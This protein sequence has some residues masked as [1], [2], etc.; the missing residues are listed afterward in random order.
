MKRLF[1]LSLGVIA[2]A[3]APAF[4][5]QPT[6]AAGPMTKVHGHVTNPSSAPQTGGVITFLEVIRPSQGPGLPA[7]T[8]ERASFDV[9]K[10]GNYSGEVPAG[11]YAVVY[12]AQGME[13]DKQADRIDGIKVVA[14]MDNQI[15]DD[16]SRAEYIEKMPE[17]QK[18]QLEEVRK[19][20]AEVF[21]ANEVIKNLNNDLRQANQ[22]EQEAG[23]AHALAVAAL[24][25]TA[26][27]TD[28]DAKEA[29]IKTAKFTD[30]ETLM[31][32]DTTAKPD[33][34][35]LWAQL[36]QAKVGLKKYDEAEPVFK[37]ALE[38]DAASKKPNPEIQ[39]I[40][41]A[42]LGEIYARTGKVAEANAAYDAAAKA[43]PTKAA[44][45]LRNEAVVFFQANN[46]DAQ[47]AAAQEALKIDPNQPVLY[48]LIGQGLVQKATIDPKTSR[49]VL[50]EGCAE[51]YQK[52]LE[53][54]PTGP[55]AADAQG[56]LAQAGQKIESSFKAGKTK[57]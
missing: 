43:N 45:Y 29:E 25:A 26:S 37:K 54:A 39:G 51:A 22:D 55:Y 47:V 17:D 12:R 30:I 28:I 24:G 20:N 8:T 36:A 3:L 14:G 13:K 40:A 4:A 23:N 7:E 2:F 32:R 5:Q 16:M 56:I 34:A 49:I 48:Y 15:D 9:D 27:K 38:V 33:A 6:P 35:V 41:Q 52:Y 44:F 21:K 18:K 50:P 1:F 53:L 57:K 31:T 11:N 46:A 19:K 10:D 42:G